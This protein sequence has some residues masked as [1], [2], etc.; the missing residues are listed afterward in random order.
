MG[1]I[2]ESEAGG[3]E[4]L[5]LSLSIA[6]QPLFN[7]T[8]GNVEGYRG[9]AVRCRMAVFDARLVLIGN[10]VLRFSGVMDKVGVKR[11]EKGGVIEMQCSRVGIARSRNIAGHRLSSAQQQVRFPGDLGLDY[12]Q[13]LIN[14]PA[15]WLSKRFQE[16]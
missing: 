14:T 5:K 4:K 6:D 16:R 8:L 10:P 7:A 12:I 1:S 11:T 15:Q 9:R 13:S 2:S 3:N